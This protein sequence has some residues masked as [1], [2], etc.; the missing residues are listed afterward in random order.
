MFTSMMTSN[1]THDMRLRIVSK[2]P[3]AFRY[4]DQYSIQIT[5]YLNVMI[6]LFYLKTA[7]NILITSRAR[8]YNTHFLANR[9]S[10]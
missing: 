8:G 4:F 9:L 3:L 10:I 6:G 2:L 1:M 7:K 5:T